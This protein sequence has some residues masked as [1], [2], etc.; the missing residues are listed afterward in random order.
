MVILF[1]AERLK[2]IKNLI[3][4]KKQV[5]VNTLSQLLN[6]SEVTIRRDLEKLESNGFLV[7]AHGG[8]ILAEFAGADP[9][10]GLLSQPG[11]DEELDDIAAIA[12]RMINDTDVIMLTDGVINN[13]IAKKL[14][15]KKNLTVLTNDISISLTL[16]GYP[17][18]NVILLGGVIDI[19][20][21]AVFGA[22][23]NSNIQ[24]FFVNKLF[25]EIEG[26]TENMQ[27]TAQT[28]EKATLIQEARNNSSENIIVAPPN[29]FM[30][31]SFYKVGDLRMADKIITSPN[32]PDSQKNYIFNQNI[33]LYTSINLFEGSV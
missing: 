33:K 14:I 12:A 20:S 15:N 24:R 21:R 1:A 28:P 16:S 29:A 27:F 23:T 2:V 4:E 31:A 19:H 3:L 17:F 5:E 25:I 7:R 18:L 9:K 11:F 8:A 6:V 13:Y 30:K 26:I 22:L 10:A 32:I